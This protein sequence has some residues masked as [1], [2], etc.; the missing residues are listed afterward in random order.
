MDK[1]S[2]CSLFPEVFQDGEESPTLLHSRCGIYIQ[3]EKEEWTWDKAGSTNQWSTSYIQPRDMLLE[4][5]VI[6]VVAQI[7]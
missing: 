7:V 1:D 6:L 5:T 2:K 3:G 4:F